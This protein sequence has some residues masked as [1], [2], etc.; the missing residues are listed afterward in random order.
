MYEFIHKVEFNRAEFAVRTSKK[1]RKLVPKLY[2]NCESPVRHSIIDMVVYE[3][4]ISLREFT[5][6]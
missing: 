4:I 5:P 6:P 2:C 3:V 1:K